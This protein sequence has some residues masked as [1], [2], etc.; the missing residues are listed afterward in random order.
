MLAGVAPIPAGGRNSNSNLVAT[1]FRAVASQLVLCYWLAWGMWELLGEHRRV[2]DALMERF[3][4]VRGGDVDSARVVLLVGPSGVGKSRIVQ[5]FY[6]S[7]DSRNC[8]VADMKPA[9]WRP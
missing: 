6:V 3:D 8:P 2:V 4:A 1:S 9:R 5:E 7:R